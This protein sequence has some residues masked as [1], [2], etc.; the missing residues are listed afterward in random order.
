LDEA[1]DLESDSALPAKVARWQFVEDLAAN[2]AV[3]ETVF[4]DP[5]DTVS[6]RNRIMHTS[7]VKDKAV[8]EI[9]TGSGLL[10]LCCLRSGAARVTAT[11]VNR[12]A[13]DNAAY[14]AGLLGFD[15]RLDLRLVSLDDPGAFSVVGDSEKFDVIISNPPWEDGQPT[16][17]DKYA[18]YDEGFLLMRS[19]FRGMSDH[20][21]P[22]GKVLLAYGCVEA[23]K[24]A[25]RLADEHGFEIDVLDDRDL[26]SLPEVFLPG[27]LLQLSP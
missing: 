26:D 9:G 17:I 14:N 19:L 1:L 23:I 2:V 10:S 11:D 3:F 25:Q 18:L 4:W 8:L 21:K 24:T 6:L 7:L 27:M 20:L 22:D 16:S 13:I 15:N 12:A 5:R